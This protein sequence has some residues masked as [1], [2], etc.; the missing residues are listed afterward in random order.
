MS[1]L[2]IC[3]TLEPLLKLEFSLFPVGWVSTNS[4]QAI[5]KGFRMQNEA[6]EIFTSTSIAA[7]LMSNGETMLMISSDLFCVGQPSS[8]Y[9][10]SIPAPPP[11][12]TLYTLHQPHPSPLSHPSPPPLPSSP[13][14][15]ATTVTSISPTH[16]KNQPHPL[17]SKSHHHTYC[18]Y[19]ASTKICCNDDKLLKAT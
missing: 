15:T 19:T 4:Y 12:Y 9:R 2:G 13:T 6:Y 3:I 11:S 16:P 5:L 18:L 10:L 14:V 7:L 17:F 1:S 8:L